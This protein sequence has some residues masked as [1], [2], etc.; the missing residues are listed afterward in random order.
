MKFKPPIILEDNL[1]LLKQMIYDTKKSREVYRPGPYWI[2]LVKNSYN[3]L[4]KLGLKNFRGI[5]SGAL[6]SIGEYNCIDVRVNYNFGIRSFM[7]SIYRNLYPFNKLFDSQVRITKIHFEEVV[8]LKTEY[9]KSHKRVKQLISKYILPPDTLR[10]GC[11]GFGKIDE[12]I[13][14]HYYLELLDTLDQ[15]NQVINIANKKSFFEIGGGFGANI[16][17]LL[18][19]F[20]NIKKIIY[21]DIPPNLYIA[22]QYLKS[23]YGESVIDYSQNKKLKKIVFSSNDDL[24][25]FC[26]I[27]SQIE[28]IFS[29]ID[30]FHNSRS[31]T[32]MPFSVVKNYGQQ[33]ERIIS[34]NGG[35]IS[36]VSYDK[37]DLNTT[38][39]P[40]KLPDLFP[41][42]KFKKEIVPTL[43][44]GRSNF[45]FVSS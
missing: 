44:L 24:E 43:D 12:K 27:P 39:D 41:N 8:R 38:F 6:S 17:L 28:K 4:I 1:D 35:N 19:N 23:F 30:I 26:I 18:H 42:R 29:E 2:K 33:I 22:T 9:Y 11:V 15:I 31:F 34:K 14:S 13:I 16:H 10:G 40:C 20:P 45:I 5:E 25:I 7:L 32:E 21:L 3:E 36:L 37:F